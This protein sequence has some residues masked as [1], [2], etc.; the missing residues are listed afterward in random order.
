MHRSR[1][2]DELTQLLFRVRKLL[3][4]LSDAVKL[5]PPQTKLGLITFSGRGAKVRI[6]LADY[7]AEEWKKEIKDY[8]PPFDDGSPLGMV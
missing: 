7:S 4:Y 1:I 2:V 3:N 6:S 5:F 8:S